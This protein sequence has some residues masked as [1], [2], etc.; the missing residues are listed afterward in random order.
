LDF[1]NFFINLDTPLNNKRRP[2]RTKIKLIFLSQL[3]F[4][5]LGDSSRYRIPINQIKAAAISLLNTGSFQIL[6][7]TLFSL[8]HNVPAD[9]L[10]H[11]VN[12]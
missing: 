12:L 1:L 11:G 7:I 10:G 6:S 9:P 4:W 3:M 8:P 5:N 2:V